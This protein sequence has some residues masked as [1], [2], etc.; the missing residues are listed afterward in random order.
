MSYID[1]KL[2]QAA[3]DR[4][5]GQISILRSLQEELAR[6]EQKI[7]DMAYT[8]EV[9]YDLKKAREEL[10]G[11]IDILNSFVRCI[12]E[13]QDV[14]QGT[15]QR[16]TDVYDLERVIHPETVFGTSRITGLDKYESLLVF[17]RKG[18]RKK[19]R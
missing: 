19:V 8:E 5:S 16:I 10:A 4:L 12:E 2:V 13:A 1:L 6:T 17:Q 7:K 15:E 18:R 11:D 14:Y 3:G 9:L